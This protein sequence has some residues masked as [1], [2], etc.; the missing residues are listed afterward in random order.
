MGI[1]PL[2]GRRKMEDALGDYF[3]TRIGVAEKR[4]AILRGIRRVSRT[5]DR[6]T[7]KHQACLGPVN[8]FFKVHTF[9]TVWNTVYIMR[10]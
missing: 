5:K 7:Q 10:L 9:M 8:K 1:V 2:W 6:P 3:E 4:Y